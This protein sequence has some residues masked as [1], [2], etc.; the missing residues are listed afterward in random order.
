MMKKSNVIPPKKKKTEAGFPPFK[1]IT[2]GVKI[3]Q[4][5]QPNQFMTVASGTTF[6][7]TISGTYSQ[8]TG[9]K[10]IP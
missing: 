2:I 8:T 6:D 3:T 5:E 7:G 9:P 10:E 4:S 1:L